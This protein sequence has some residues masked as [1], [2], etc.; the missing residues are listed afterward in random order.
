MKISDMLPARWNRQRSM[1]TNEEQ[2]PFLALHKEMNRLFDDFLDGFG[3]VSPSGNGM[4]GNGVPSVDVSETETEVHVEAELPG[5]D[6]K[7]LDL[8]LSAGVLYLRGEKKFE[9]EEKQKNFL[10]VERSYGTFQRAIPLP[11][12]IDESKVDAVFRKGVLHVT[13]S[14]TKASQPHKKISVKTSD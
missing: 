8:T 7:D 6:E 10:R 14:K 12:E 11:A 3:T 1:A 9:K 4:F 13:L 2:S 5:V